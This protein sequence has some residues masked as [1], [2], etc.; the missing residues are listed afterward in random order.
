M[1]TQTY[2]SGAAVL[3]ALLPILPLMLYLRRRSS[4]QKP[5][6]R[7]PVFLALGSISLLLLGVGVALA[8]SHG[9]F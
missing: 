4:P 9:T 6:L 3:I 5:P 7:N 1:D 8:A 2:S